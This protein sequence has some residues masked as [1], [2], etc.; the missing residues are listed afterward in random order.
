MHL[1][2][3]A[4]LLF[5]LLTGG[6][7]LVCYDCL[8]QQGPCEEQM[9]CNSVNNSCTSRRE[10]EYNGDTVTETNVTTCAL[11]DECESWSFNTGY[12]RRSHSIQC[13]HKDLCNKQV[14]PDLYSDQ[15]GKKC[16]TCHEE[17]CSHTVSCRG[18]EDFCFTG[19]EPP[20]LKGCA[21]KYFCDHAWNLSRVNITC[22]SGNLC[23]S[24]KSV[25]QSFL[26]LC[27]SLLSFIL[28]H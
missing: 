9:T 15:N 7:S 14:G 20:I 26:F 18:N 24:V 12:K 6:F 1:Q 10:V 16:H 23:N 13:C 4:V 8:N 25:T 2:T 21:S 17:D 22:C 5:I 3:S 19:Y 27:C 28:L 11:P